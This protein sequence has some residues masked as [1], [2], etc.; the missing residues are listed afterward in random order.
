MPLLLT[1]GRECTQGKALAHQSAVSEGS[2]LHL[3]AVGISFPVFCSVFHHSCSQG[4]SARPPLRC[5][6]AHQFRMKPTFG[7]LMAYGS[8]DIIPRVR[9]CGQFF[10]WLFAFSVLGFEF[11]DVKPQ[12]VSS[13]P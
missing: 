7:Q 13:F 1:E 9:T 6:G 5:S 10:L 3:E 11:T 4:L 12:L 2:K 8:L